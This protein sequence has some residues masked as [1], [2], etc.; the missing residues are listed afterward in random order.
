MGYRQDEQVIRCLHCGDFDTNKNTFLH[1]IG[2]QLI[3]LNGDRNKTMLWLSYNHNW[4]YHTDEC[5]LQFRPMNSFLRLISFMNE[6]WLKYIFA[7]IQILMKWSLQNELSWDVQKFV[8]IWLSGIGLIQTVFPMNIKCDG[9]ITE[10]CRLVPCSVSMLQ[11]G[12]GVASLTPISCGP[13][14]AARVT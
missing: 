1:Y 11:C 7:I 8:V 6:I 14:H 4:K 2:S 12:A 3:L 5:S 13:H 10:M 9:K